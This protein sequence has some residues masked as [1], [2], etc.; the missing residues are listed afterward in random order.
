MKPVAATLDMATTHKRDNERQHKMLR[1][2]E[3]VTLSHKTDLLDL[4]FKFVSLSLKQFYFIRF[5]FQVTL[6]HESFISIELGSYAIFNFS[7]VN[8]VIVVWFI[9]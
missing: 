9:F 3:T 5:F 6:K 8:R 1:Y 7:R 4:A 2:T